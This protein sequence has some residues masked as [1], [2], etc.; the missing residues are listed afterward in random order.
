M[1]QSSRTIILV[2]QSDKATY[3]YV[4]SF[5]EANK[6]AVFN[7]FIIEPAAKE[8]SIRQIRDINKEVVYSAVDTRLYVLLKFDTASYE[9][10]NAFLK[11]LEQPPEGVW[12]ILVVSNP[13]LLLPTVRSRSLIRRVSSGTEKS[14]ASADADAALTGLIGTSDLSVLEDKAFSGKSYGNPAEFFD[15]VIGFFRN[16]LRSDTKAPGMLRFAL[17]IRSVVVHNHGDVQNGIDQILIKIT[18][19]YL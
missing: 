3:E 16:R 13:Q 6:V 14:A 17:N 15:Y 5:A 18:N 10:Q 9:A 8:F 12:F 11:T 2:S 1:S 19:V 4:N 7:K